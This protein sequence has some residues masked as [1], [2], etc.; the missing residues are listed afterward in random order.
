MHL[1]QRLGVVILGLWLVGC[2]NRSSST[3]KSQSPSSTTAAAQAGMSKYP[4][5]CADGG[6][7]I[8]LPAEAAGI[9]TGVTSMQAALN[10]KSDYGRACAATAN[11]QLGTIP[12]GSA[13]ALVFGEPPMI[14]WGKSADGL[15]EVYLLEMWNTTNLDTLVTK[16]TAALP[17]ASMTNSGIPLRFRE[18]D[19][20]LLF[21]GDTP[22]S[23]AYGV[24]RVSIPPGNYT[25]LV[26]TYSMSGESVTVYR[27]QPQDR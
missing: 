27:L 10:P 13:K 19:A 1:M 2:D 14:A 4:Y 5:N 16:A 12:V 17:T 21:A 3:A 26:G 15:T 11:A 22:T 6:P 20:F 24:H 9:W 25:V 7:F 23:T 18:A 8:L